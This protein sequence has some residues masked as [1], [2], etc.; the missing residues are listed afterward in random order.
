MHQRPVL[1]VAKAEEVLD[2]V[3]VTGSL[4]AALRFLRNNYR[5]SDLPGLAELL[6]RRHGQ[7][8]K[9][10]IT[11]ISH[12]VADLDCASQGALV[13]KHLEEQIPK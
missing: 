13:K 11:W 8:R 9:S 12:A 6:I 2:L 5:G 10:I 7:T 1:S 3:R 4:T